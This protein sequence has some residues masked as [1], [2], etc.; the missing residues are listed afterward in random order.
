MS[1]SITTTRSFILCGLEAIPVTI[2]CRVH[3]SGIGIHLA[4]LPD[5]SV[6]E[7]LLRTATALMSRGFRIPGRKIVINITPAIDPAVSEASSLD[8]PI[9]LTLLRASGQRP[10]PC[11]EEYLVAGELM[12]D[13]RLRSIPG[14]YPAALL[15]D[16]ENLSLLLPAETAEE[17]PLAGGVKTFA[18]ASLADA[19][20][21]AS[22]EGE[23]HT[24]RP[25]AAQPPERPRSFCIS[26]DTLRKIEIAAAGGY[27]VL[28]TGT[29]QAN[30]EAARLLAELVNDGS[31]LEERRRI[32]SATGLPFG[33]GPILRCPDRNTSMAALCGGGGKCRPGEVTLA[34]GGVLYLEDTAL[35]PKTAIEVLAGIHEDGRAVISRLKA[36]I[37]YPAKFTVAFSQGGSGKMI[38]KALEVTSRFE[39]MHIATAKTGESLPPGK[40][41]EAKTR[42]KEARKRIERLYGAGVR[43]AKIASRE[44]PGLPANLEKLLDNMILGLN[45]SA[46][47]Y[48]DI[49][50][51]ALA[52]AALDGKEEADCGCLAEAASYRYL[53]KNN[54]Q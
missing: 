54:S 53:A 34:D 39:L 2:E 48:N 49:R 27:D 12:L 37:E 5:A 45:L 10:M 8:L 11:L 33:T 25:R 36:K 13:G 41:E 26:G 15:A 17:I 30:I 42:V 28:L 47:I 32:C 18:A 29:P 3:E 43:A 1:T 31:R 16:K 44:L 9:A 6:K 7:S 40:I 22:G 52:I 50:R 4:G 23:E 14:G 38:G 24:E 35:W 21:V 19:I 20:A 51:I 46:S